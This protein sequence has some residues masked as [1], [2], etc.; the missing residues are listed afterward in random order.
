MKKELTVAL[1]ATWM[2]GAAMASGS[3]VPLLYRSAPTDEATAP[4]PLVARSPAAGGVPVRLVSAPSG[5]ITASFDAAGRYLYLGFSFHADGPFSVVVAPETPLASVQVLVNGVV[6]LP[7]GGSATAYAASSTLVGTP[8]VQI[9][10]ERGSAGQVPLAVSLRA[11]T[12]CQPLAPAPCGELLDTPPASLVYDLSD[13]VADPFDTQ[14]DLLVPAIV[15]GAGLHGP[16]RSALSVHNPA[17]APVRLRL[18]LS[19]LGG[20]FSNVVALTVP[21]GERSAI[22]DLVGWLYPGTPDPVGQGV[23]EIQGFV[24]PSPGDLTVETAYEGGGDGRLGTTLPLFVDPLSE[25]SPALLTAS[26]KDDPRLTLFSALPLPATASLSRR[27]LLRITLPDGTVSLN[28]IDVSGGPV[29]ARLSEL[30]GLPVEGSAISFETDDP[31][32]HAI[33]VRSDPVTGSPFVVASK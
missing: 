1:A 9:R 20:G 14:A 26:T 31:S 30:V 28:P 11:L 4:V 27:A 25:G 6:F 12:P 29:S 3:G 23:L 17:D 15:R 18:F 19:D 16:I 2:S 7:L 24:P 22:P 5:R 10:L 21:A 33:L 13:G 8:H 32:L